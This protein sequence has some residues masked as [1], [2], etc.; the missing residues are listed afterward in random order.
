MHIHEP[1]INQ[2]V[3]GIWIGH[4]DWLAHECVNAHQRALTRTVRT[5]L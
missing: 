5:H 3:L 2:N 1:T 4:F